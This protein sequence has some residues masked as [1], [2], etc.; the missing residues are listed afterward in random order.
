VTE[1]GVLRLKNERMG[2][3]IR[4]LVSLAEPDRN[5]VVDDLIGRLAAG[6]P[7]EPWRWRYDRDVAETKLRCI[8]GEPDLERCADIAAAVAAVDAS[9]PDGFAVA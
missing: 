5:S 8:A 9:D 1:N 3:A 7:R 4:S 2:P 6:A